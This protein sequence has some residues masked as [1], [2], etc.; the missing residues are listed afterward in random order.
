[1][2]DCRLIRTVDPSAA[3][4][5]GSTG[6]SCGFRG[7]AAPPPIGVMIGCFWKRC[8]IIRP[9]T[10]K[11]LRQMERRVKEF[12]QSSKTAVFKQCIFEMLL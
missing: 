11:A 3:R 10:A 12:E 5:T 1:V 4:G 8:I 9:S 7:V 6:D 2:L